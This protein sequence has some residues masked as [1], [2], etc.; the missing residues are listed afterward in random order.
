MFFM[1]IL[2]VGAVVDVWRTRTSSG[3]S[4]LAL[5]LS[6]EA[7]ALGGLPNSQRLLSLR[8]RQTVR[9]QFE[10]D[11]QIE[12]EGVERVRRAIA[13]CL[14]RQ[15]TRA[16]LFEAIMADEEGTSIICRPSLSSWT[17]RAR[18]ATSRSAWAARPP[19][20][21]GV[22]MPGLSASLSA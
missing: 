19:D 5:G 2:V 3:L 13:R 10:S 4:Y 7:A 20:Q 1:V 14:E 18:R 6:E 17:S 15:D 22:L 12:L 21:T 8:V 16:I 9:E 11:L